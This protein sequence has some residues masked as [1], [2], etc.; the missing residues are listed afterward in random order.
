SAIRPLPRSGPPLMTTRVG[1]PAVCESMTSMRRISRLR[2][3]RT[4]LDAVVDDFQH[5]FA[6]F[7]RERQ[8]RRTHPLSAQPA[9]LRGQLD[10]LHELDVHIQMQQRREPAVN[11]Q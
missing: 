6:L 1:S 10:V 5:R 3:L 11:R 7:A 9:F 4:I 2:K 8:A